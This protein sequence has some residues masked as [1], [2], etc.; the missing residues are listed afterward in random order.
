ME[1]S[2]QE[3]SGRRAFR[4]LN[5]KPIMLSI[6]DSDWDKSPSFNNINLTGQYQPDY[7]EALPK[8]ISIFIAINIIYNNKNIGGI[9]PKISIDVDKETYNKLKNEADK[10]KIKVSK[11]AEEKLSE[12]VHKEWPDYYRN[13]FGTI[14]DESF[15]VERPPDLINR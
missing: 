1:I 9:M 2:S 12:S 4:F 15:K 7:P 14:K 13:L 3:V 8:T 5:L 11:Y 6:D 10:K